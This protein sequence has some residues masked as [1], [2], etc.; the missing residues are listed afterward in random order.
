MFPHMHLG[1]FYKIYM[2]KAI[3]FYRIFEQ[4]FTGPVVCW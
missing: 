2:S 3:Q 4:Q 1:T